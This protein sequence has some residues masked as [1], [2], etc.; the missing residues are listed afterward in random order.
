M[1]GKDTEV[2]HP[3]PWRA[4]WAEKGPWNVFLR[5]MVLSWRVE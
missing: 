5:E 2:P 3:K 1:R 4:L